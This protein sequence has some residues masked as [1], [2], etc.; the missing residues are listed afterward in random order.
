M[1][2]LTVQQLIDLLMKVEDK[3]NTTVW[4]S[5]DAPITGSLGIDDNH[6][7]ILEN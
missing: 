2:A 5:K 1:N 3:E 7:L 6:A 4:T